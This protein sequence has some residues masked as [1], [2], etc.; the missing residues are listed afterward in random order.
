[1]AVGDVRGDRLWC[2]GIVLLVLDVPAGSSGLHD[3]LHRR[4]IPVVRR[5]QRMAIQEGAVS[6]VRDGEFTP[7]APHRVFPLT[8]GTSLA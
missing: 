7:I 4:T 8:P 6:F 2:S 1:M 3:G 5:R